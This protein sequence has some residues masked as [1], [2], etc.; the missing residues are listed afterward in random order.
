MEN[1]QSHLTLSILDELE[2]LNK[3][4]VIDVADREK[5][6]K[7]LE[8]IIKAL[9][10]NNI[11]L[12]DQLLTKGQH[13]LANVYPQS[14]LSLEKLQVDVNRRQEEQFRQ[15]YLELEEYCKA[16]RIPFKG[17]GTK[18]IVDTF[19]D[20]ELDRKNT[21]SKI[22][23]LSLSTIKW[24]KVREAIEVE[25]T[26]LWHRNFNPTFF[27]DRLVLACKELGSTVP[28]PSGWISLEGVYQILKRR[29]ENDNPD[30][31]KGGRL[32]AYYKDE[33]SV[34][35]SLLWEAQSRNEIRSPHIGLSAIR[36]IRKAFKVLQPDSNI[37]F[38][39]FIRIEGD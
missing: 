12:V 26:R 13:L 39:G 32:V 31:K 9:R 24:P 18:F 29:K 35:L 20:I 23:V 21:R 22:G 34:D 25:R 4:V 6:K 3:T 27:R 5:A 28:S 14:K 30:W 38:F 33:F 10:D 7:L 8:N 2:V 19:I 36:D 15:T 37:G 1:E 16:N 17:S 11:E